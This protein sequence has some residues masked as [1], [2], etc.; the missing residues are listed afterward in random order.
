M[1]SSSS[2]RIE[3]GSDAPLEDVRVQPAG[4]NAT[5]DRLLRERER[6]AY[7]AGV[8]AGLAELGGVVDRTLAQLEER[9]E[10]L[11]QSAARTAVEL[12]VEIAR[13]LLEREIEAGNYGLE[14]IVRET[15]RESGVGREEC[16]VHLNE[17][18]LEALANVPFRTGTNLRESYGI[19]RGEVQVDSHYGLLVRDLDEALTSI[20]ER[21]RGELS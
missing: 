18:D 20:A 6:A 16:V 1:R 9:R 13:A 14:R 21:L 7:A 4:L 2:V 8:Q 15:L 12:G 10:E 11:T 17:A 3:L 19:A 5:V